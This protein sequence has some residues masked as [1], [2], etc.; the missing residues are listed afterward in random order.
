M[1]GC[2]DSPRRATYFSFLRQRNLRKRKATRSLSPCASLRARCGAREKRG[3]AQTRFA[4]TSA[5]PDPLF[6]VLLASARTGWETNA[7]T[8]PGA[9]AD[10]D[11]LSLLPGEGRGEGIPEPE[12]LPPPVL[13]G[14]EIFGR[15]GLKNLDVRRPR[16]G[17]VSRF[18]VPGKYFKEPQIGPDCGSPF[19]LLPLLFAKQKKSELPPGNGR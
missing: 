6:P 7:G 19:L 10:S 14:L 5:C 11:F 4:Q 13:A 1:R 17:L 12:S 16:S 3:H 9:R 15:D 8:G 18:S 2:R